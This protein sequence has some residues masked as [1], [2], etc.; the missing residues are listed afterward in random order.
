MTTRG[1][2]TATFLALMSWFL[3][4]VGVMWWTSAAPAA[5]VLFPSAELI[6]ALDHDIRILDHDAY[7]ITLASNTPDLSAVLY[8]DGARLILP[9]GLTGCLSWIGQKS[10]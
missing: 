3:L 8:R 1:L 7:S 4:L 10:T 2:L 5:R 6:G 9:A